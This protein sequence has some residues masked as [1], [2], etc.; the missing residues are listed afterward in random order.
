MTL[1]EFIKEISELKKRNRKLRRD[2]KKLELAKTEADLQ[3]KLNNGK[4]YYLLSDPK[5]NP[6]PANMYQI[7]MMQKEGLM[8]KN[9]NIKNILEECLYYTNITFNTHYLKP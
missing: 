6:V 5:G 1:L 2:L 9:V 7:K 8:F 3:S 4:R